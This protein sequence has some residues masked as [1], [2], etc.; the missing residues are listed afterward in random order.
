MATSIA[1]CHPAFGFRPAL[2]GLGGA[3]LSSTA[4]KSSA[5]CTLSVR[6]IASNVEI[7][8][9]S[10]PRSTRPKY[11]R[12]VPAFSASRSC[13]SPLSTRRRRKF[14]P[15]VANIHNHRC[16][17]LPAAFA[18]RFQRF[19]RCSLN[20]HFEENRNIDSERFG[21]ASEK[22]NRGVELASF[23]AAYRRSIN[24]SVHSKVLL[25]NAFGSPDLPEIPSDACTM[26]HRGMATILPSIN[27]SNIYHIFRING[28]GCRIGIHLGVL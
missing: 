11:D 15:I 16:S 25:R 14:H 17:E 9:F 24:A 10:T 5:T 12:S 3:D 20:R 23:N 7:V 8:T 1:R 2:K 19:R 4:A 21:E 26:F 28:C 18:T 6:D 22:I 27:P 13:E